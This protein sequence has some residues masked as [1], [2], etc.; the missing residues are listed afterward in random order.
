[1]NT[2]LSTSVMSLSM[3]DVETRSLGVW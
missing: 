3:D 2:D 1:M